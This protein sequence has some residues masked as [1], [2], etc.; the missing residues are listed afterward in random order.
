MRLKLSLRFVMVLPACIAVAMWWLGPLT[1]PTI[2][3]TSRQLDV[4]IVGPGYFRVVNDKVCEPRYTRT[5][6]IEVNRDRMLSIVIA[7]E[8]Y[9][10]DPPITVPPESE[11]IEIA[12]DGFVRVVTPAG[13]QTVGRFQ[14]SR[15][16]SELPFDSP[17]LFNS[18]SRRSGIEKTYDP[19]VGAGFLDQGCL[20]HSFPDTWTIISALA[21]ALLAS[22]VLSY[23]F[24][25]LFKS[26]NQT[27]QHRTC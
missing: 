14:I 4:A 2:V 19:S 10:I 11:Q 20:E 12:D 6:R 21:I 1:E 23:A 24:V 25:I 13:T 22:L 26:S 9:P 5:G 17:W 18:A 27:P 16:G 3:H 15:F 7:G 8:H